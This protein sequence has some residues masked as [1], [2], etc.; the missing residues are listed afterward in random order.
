M[1]SDLV[2][3]AITLSRFRKSN[4]DIIRG[5]L[6]LD[7]SLTLDEMK[8]LKLVLPTDEEV[9]SIFSIMS[10]RSSHAG[11]QI[12]SLKRFKGDKKTLGMSEQMLLLLSSVPKV[13][14]RLDCAI[15]SR[16]FGSRIGEIRSVS[17]C[18]L[19]TLLLF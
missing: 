7:E 4:S 8:S 5:L 3:P 19:C 9:C 6:E 17:C 16:E 13:E 10:W 11:K 15:L 2:A 1:Q 14:S 12:Q 18:H